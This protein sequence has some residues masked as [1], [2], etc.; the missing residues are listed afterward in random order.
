VNPHP[1]QML[2][3]AF[4]VFADAIEEQDWERADRIVDIAVRLVRIESATIP[5]DR[6]LRDHP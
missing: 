3:R 1:D 6:D 2:R 5:C 4:K